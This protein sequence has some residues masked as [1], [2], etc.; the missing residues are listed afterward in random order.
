M[1]T[2][3]VV[4]GRTEWAGRAV[5]YGFGVAP[6]GGTRDVTMTAL[7]STVAVIMLSLC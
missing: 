6:D 7:A 3:G 1:T 5:V 2:L 4:R